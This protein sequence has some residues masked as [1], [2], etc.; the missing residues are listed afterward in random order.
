MQGNIGKGGERMIFE[1]LVTTTHSLADLKR[2]TDLKNNR[3][4]QENTDARY[5]VLLSQTDS[6]VS[7]IDY[8]YSDAKAEKNTDILS[9]ISELLDSLEKV[10][11]SGLANQ[12]EVSKA[13]NAYKTLQVNMKKEWSKQ[14]ISITG[15][16]IS[17][18]EA[19]KGIDPDNVTDCIQKIA[20]AE[21]WEVGVGRLQT[22]MKGIEN[23]EQ[24][25]QKLGL[26]DEIILFLQNTNVGKATLKDLNDKVLTWIRDEKLDNK[27]RISFVR[28]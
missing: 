19:I 2:K 18:L 3:A 7:T 20:A 13:E 22:M 11:E 14:Y 10:I 28:K 21:N 25:I 26:D 23:A 15:A 8:L 9:G 16:T 24:L 6:F 4:M 27:I 5:R 1:E 17:T 12:E